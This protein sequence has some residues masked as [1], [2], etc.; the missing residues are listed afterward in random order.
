MTDPGAP[1]YSGTPTAEKDISAVLIT[2]EHQDHVHIETLKGIL[3]HNPTA[4]VIT[5][6]SV[7]TVLAEAEIPFTLVEEGQSI[8]IAGVVVSGFGNTHAEIYH[9]FG[10]V[11]NTGYMID[12]LC[13]PGDAFHYPDREVDILALPVSAPWLKIKDAIEYAKHIRPRIVFP[14]HDGFIKEFF[15]PIYVL[16]ERI[17][18]EVGIGFKKLEI[19]KEEEL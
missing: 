13:Y 10:Q 17:L 5:N 4:Q 16:P 6:T 18:S 14:V 19:G 9:Q 2:H 15:T 1:S 11:Q 3:K 12:T 7:G 8:D